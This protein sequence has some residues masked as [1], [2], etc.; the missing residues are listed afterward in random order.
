MLDCLTQCSQPAAH[1]Y[2]MSSSYRS[3][4]LGFHTGTLTL[5]V[6][7]VAYSCMVEWFRWDSSVISTTN[8]FPSYWHC[9]FGHLACKNRPRN[10]IYVLSGTLSLHTITYLGIF[11]LCYTNL[12]IIII[13]III[14][15][16]APVQRRDIKCW[17]LS[18]GLCGVGRE[19]ERPRPPIILVGRATIIWPHQ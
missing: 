8:C 6:E 12:L 11:I 15:I 7:A 14:I 2:C 17:F 10:D 1:L 16:T 18:W 3:N 19:G 4:R 5:C 13:I 9:C